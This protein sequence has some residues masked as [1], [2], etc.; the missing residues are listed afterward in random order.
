MDANKINDKNDIMKEEPK[1][2]DD[3]GFWDGAITSKGK[4]NWLFVGIACL[5]LIGAVALLGQ[6]IWWDKPEDGI[7]LGEEQQNGNALLQI[8][9]GHVAELP[10]EN[11]AET[12]ANGTEVQK[13]GENQNLDTEEAVNQEN[14]T[15]EPQADAPEEEIPTA[16]APSTWLPPAVAEISRDYGYGFDETYQDYRFHGGLDWEMGMGEPVFAVAPGTVESA[17]EDAQWGGRVEISHGGGFKSVYLGLIP[18]GLVEGQA[19]EGGETIGTISPAP[20]SEAAQGSHLHLELWRD[21]ERLNPG[22]YISSN[23]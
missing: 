7:Q 14:L 6:E 12:A 15:V 22:D 10:E 9:G 23:Q 11:E 18:A 8:G 13:P 3:G 17:S 1:K 2:T 4:L 20:T 16:A 5:V 21:G 19:V